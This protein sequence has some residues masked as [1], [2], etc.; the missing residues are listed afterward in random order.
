MLLNSWQTHIIAKV[1]H[2]VHIGVGILVDEVVDHHV[3]DVKVRHHANLD[4][5]RTNGDEA[6]DLVWRERKIGMS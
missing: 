4:A 5:V 2:V 1:P 3:D 6:A